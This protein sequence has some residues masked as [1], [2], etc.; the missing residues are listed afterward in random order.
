MQP[1]RERHLSKILQKATRLN[2]KDLPNTF[3]EASA[4]ADIYIWYRQRY[5]RFKK[6]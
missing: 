5:Y 6:I 1:S 3:G 2:L 4:I